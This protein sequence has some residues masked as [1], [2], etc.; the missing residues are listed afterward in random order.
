[1]LPKDRGFRSSNS[2]ALAKMAAGAGAGVLGQ[3][4]LMICWLMHCVAVPKL[5]CTLKRGRRCPRTGASGAPTA[6]PWPRWL[7]ERALACLGRCAL[8]ALLA[9][10]LPCSPAAAVNVCRRSEPP[11]DRGCCSCLGQTVHGIP[12]KPAMQCA[13]LWVLP[14]CKQLHISL[15]CSDK[16][17]RTAAPWCRL[18]GTAAARS[19]TL[20]PQSGLLRHR[21][22]RASCTG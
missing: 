9:H 16:G 3:V 17:C 6:T 14:C 10:V 2:Y 19:L 7:Q 22:L 1:M 21:R 5:R 20:G 11:K 8:P 12:A 15:A 4:C 13:P 18:C